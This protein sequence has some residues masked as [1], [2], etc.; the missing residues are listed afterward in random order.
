MFL[1][2]VSIELQINKKPKNRNDVNEQGD[3][4]HVQF[5]VF[6]SLDLAMSIHNNEKVENI[7]IFLTIL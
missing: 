5:D 2:V 1:L 3:L 4:A 6:G 7:I